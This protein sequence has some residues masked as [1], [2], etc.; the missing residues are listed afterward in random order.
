MRSTLWLASIA[1]LLATAGIFALRHRT[2]LETATVTI[3]R[4]T[5]TVAVADSPREQLQG[6]RDRESVPPDGGMLFVFGGEP[7]NR[8]FTMDG[9]R[10]PLDFLWIA[11][12]RIV[13]LT[14][15][16]PPAARGTGSAYPSPEPVDAVLEIRGGKAQQWGFSVGDSVRIEHT[17][18]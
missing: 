1:L 18:E 4:A 7:V 12:G 2:S 15:E 13:G 14:L 9:V 16:A 6:L 17:G 10:L 8:T 5:F 11:R 3:R